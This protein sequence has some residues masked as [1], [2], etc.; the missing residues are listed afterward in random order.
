MPLINKGHQPA[1]ARRKP[2]GKLRRTKMK[3][4]LS[5]LEKQYSFGQIKISD[6]I[7][8]IEL[9]LMAHGKKFKNN[10]K[11]WCFEE[12]LWRAGDFLGEVIAI[13]KS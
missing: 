8:E 13:L 11:N 9:L 4:G 10:N 5:E 6:Q 7:K 3:H 12:D 2:G 1:P